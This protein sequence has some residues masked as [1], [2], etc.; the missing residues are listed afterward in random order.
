MALSFDSIAGRQL[1][2]H[3]AIPSTLDGLILVSR[4]LSRA[5]NK[6]PSNPVGCDPRQLDENSV[7][8]SAS[9]G[10]AYGSHSNKIKKKPD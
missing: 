7:I 1:T 6:P 9:S 2:L 8:I 10:R 3:M 4:P 5:R